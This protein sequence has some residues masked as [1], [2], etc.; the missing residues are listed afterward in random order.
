MRSLVSI[1]A[2][3]LLAGCASSSGTPQAPRASW[4]LVGVDGQRSTPS[5]TT[6]LDR[7]GQQ[8]TQRGAEPLAFARDGQVESLIGTPPAETMALVR[9]P[10][11]R[12]ARDWYKSDAYQ[13]LVPLRANSGT[14]WLAGFEGIATKMPGAHPA[15]LVLRGELPPPDA[16]EADAIKHYGGVVVARLGDGDLDVFEGTPPKGAWRVIAFPSRGALAAL[17]LDPEFRALRE[18]WNVSGKTSAVLIDAV[19]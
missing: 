6:Y 14:Y 4:L 11:A 1:L 10:T 16:A 19:R 9:F 2:V 17:W 13:Q 8:Y 15:F 3:L 5:L 7:V 12:G 18:S